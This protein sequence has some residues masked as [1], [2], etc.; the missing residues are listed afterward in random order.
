MTG[1]GL[2][3]VQRSKKGEEEA[4]SFIETT[5]GKQLLYAALHAGIEYPSPEFYVWI[6]STEQR[7]KLD[8][9]INEHERRKLPRRRLPGGTSPEWYQLFVTSSPMK[10]EPATRFGCNPFD[11]DIAGKYRC[12]LGLREH[13][14]GLNL[15]SQVTVQGEAWQGGDFL[16]SRELVG[17]RRGLFNPKPL[18]FVSPRL[19]DLLLKNAVKGWSTEAANV[20]SA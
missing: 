19:R 18:L 3:P 2:G 1:F 7:D 8:R 6:N 5:S 20:S 9:A 4:F 14:V 11:D 15:L 13:V 17:V 10:L 16:R 12:P